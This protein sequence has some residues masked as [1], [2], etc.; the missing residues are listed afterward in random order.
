MLF[1]SL[2]TLQRIADRDTLKICLTNVFLTG[3]LGYHLDN[4]NSLW[5]GYWDV[6]SY[7]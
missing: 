7:L 4:G 6:L 3:T 5:I 2:G 1:I